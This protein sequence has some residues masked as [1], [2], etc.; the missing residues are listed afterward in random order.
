MEENEF[1][2]KKKYVYG[3]LI[4]AVLVF[5]LFA[6][7]FVAKNRNPATRN[8]ATGMMNGN[9]S[10]NSMADHHK[11]SQAKPSGFFENA[12]GKQAPDFELQDING[13]LVKLSNF[14][15]KNVVLFFNEGS[16]CYPACWNQISSFA[17]DERFN[18][19]DV[20]AFSIV[21]DTI[22]QWQQI[23]KKV[24][25]LS[26]SKILF[27]TSKKV[28]ADYDVLYVDSSMHKGSYPGHTYFA[29]DKNGI[30]RYVK[31]D[32]NMAINNDEIAAELDKIKGA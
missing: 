6:Y 20:I 16:M 18:K 13:N 25:Q 28:S 24:P 19:E 9:P 26:K 2:I 27:D 10:S 15:G 11:P 7:S 4:L 8:Q 32:S 29:I 1:R 5:G 17:N 31:D 21:V 3:G 12:V 22:S 23:L 30:I 14:K